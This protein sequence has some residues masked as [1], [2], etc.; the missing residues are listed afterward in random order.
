MKI[1]DRFHTCIRQI[2]SLF[3]L[4]SKTDLNP[5]AAAHGQRTFQ[6]KCPFLHLLI[7]SAILHTFLKIKTF[8]NKKCML[9]NES[10]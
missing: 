8:S 7:L 9:K 1:I 2:L 10:I 5:N 3:D 6:L 4:Q